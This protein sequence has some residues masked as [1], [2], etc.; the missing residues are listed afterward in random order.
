MWTESSRR[1]LTA[2]IAFA[3][4]AA[5]IAGV[6]LPWLSVFNGLRSYSGLAGL[7]GRVLAAGGAAAMLAAAW[8][9]ARGRTRMRYAIGALGFALALFS[10]YLITQ[11]LV[12]YHSL[13][14]MFVPAL[15]PGVFVAA[16]GALLLV[17]TL[18]IDPRA[19]GNQRPASRLDARLAAL[20]A[21]SAGAGAIHLSVASDHFHEYWLFGAFFV[22]LGIAQVGWATLVAIRGRSQALLIAAIGNSAV[23]ALWIASR[24]TGL[25]LGSHPGAPE[26]LGFPDVSATLFEVLL[27]GCAAWSLRQWSPRQQ[28]GPSRR[29]VARLAW[30]LPL[31]VSSSAI[32]AIVIGVGAAG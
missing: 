19:P 5:V 22:T 4:G 9:C 12:T 14:G 32:V 10:A 29:A 24:T 21:L 25:P 13:Q 26:A 8:Y 27:A 23:V 20:I 6:T 17:A 18:L 31:A 16:G 28:R 7:N 30:A 2:A 11:L 15:G 3:G 1:R